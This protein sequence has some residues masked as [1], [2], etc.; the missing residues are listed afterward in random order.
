MRVILYIRVK[1]CYE[2]LK[3]RELDEKSTCA[4][5]AQTDNIEKHYQKEHYRWKMR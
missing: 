2:T 3:E 4:N 5:F 1:C